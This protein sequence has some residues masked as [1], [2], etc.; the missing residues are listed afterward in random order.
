MRGRLI[1]S[2]MLICFSTQLYYDIISLK[3]IPAFY[4]LLGYAEN[5]GIFW[6]F[7]I[8]NGVWI[9]EGSDNGD[10]DNQGS[11]VHHCSGTMVCSKLLENYYIW[12]FSRHTLLG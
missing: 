10:L 6:D 7:T 2:H 9:T 5:Q 8:K 11:T 3:I 4:L 12:S 1:I